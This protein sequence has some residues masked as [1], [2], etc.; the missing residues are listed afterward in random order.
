M[1]KSPTPVPRNNDNFRRLQSIASVFVASILSVFCVSP[2]RGK[3]DGQE[4]SAVARLGAKS[5]GL[6]PS[7]VTVRIGNIRVSGTEIRTMPDIRRTIAFVIDAGPDQS[8]VVSREKELAVALIHELSDAVTSFIVVSAVTSSRTLVTALDGPV[9]I[10]HIHD[11]S[12]ESG[13]RRNVAVYDA[14]GGAIRQISCAPGLRVVIF[15]G[16]GND[17]GSTLRYPE[18]RNLAES[19]HI[20]FFSALVANHSLRGTKSI[21]RYG[22]N[23]RELAGDTAGL[24]VENQKTSKT[25]R[26]LSENIRRLRLVTFEMSRPQSGRYKLSVSSK[27]NGLLKAQKA[28]VIP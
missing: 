7:D 19:Y 20:G 2:E 12:G 4:Y 6:T 24:F 11:I 1:M 13:Q 17:E 14:I 25:T 3:A 18:L 9:A 15:I 26:Q 16:E 23:L 21:L 27:R 5:L 10:E 22:W 28:I 8:Q